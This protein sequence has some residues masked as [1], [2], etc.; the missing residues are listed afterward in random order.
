M[1]STMQIHLY[2]TNPASP[3]LT[4][5]LPADPDAA[6]RGRNGWFCPRQIV[7]WRG[8]QVWLA[9]RSRRMGDNAPIQL[10]ISPTAAHA[11]G[12]ALLAATAD[13]IVRPGHP[14]TLS[15]EVEWHPDY[16][17]GDYEDTGESTVIEVPVGPG[18]T[19]T[20][21]LVDA[22]F[23]QAT[24]QD[25]IHI[26][27]WVE[28]AEPVGGYRVCSVCGADIAFDPLDMHGCE[29]CQ[30]PICPACARNGHRFCRACA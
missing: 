28:V 6:A 21:A 30:E 27:R 11:L 9:V 13:S 7:I 12:G 3:D 1:E 29:H 14:Q 25:P 22:A 4:T 26:M 2:L 18:A 24:G 15:V 16:R 23:A 20:D 5:E 8:A 19:V 10:Q 17:G